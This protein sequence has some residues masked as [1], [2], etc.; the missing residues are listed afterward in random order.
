MIRVH[1]SHRS[2]FGSEMLTGVVRL[3]DAE[4][5]VRWLKKRTDQHGDDPVIVRKIEIVKVDA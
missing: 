2:P 1:Y 5:L 4:H 3:Q